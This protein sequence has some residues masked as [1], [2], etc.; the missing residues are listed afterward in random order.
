MAANAA[1]VAATAGV[2]VVAATA[3]TMRSH[4]SGTDGTMVLDSLKVGATQVPT[5]DF[6]DRWSAM[7]ALSPTADTPQHGLDVR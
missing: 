1:G 6:D 4:P 5:A 3:A 7:F 2:V